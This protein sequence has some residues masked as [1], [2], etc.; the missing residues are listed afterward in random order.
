LNRQPSKLGAVEPK[1]LDDQQLEAWL[2]F[3]RVLVA[4]PAELDSEMQRRAGITQFEYG[5]LARLSEAPGRTMRIS[6]LAED[7]CGSLSRLSH[8]INRLE[9]RGWIR[10]ELD[11]EDGRYTNAILTGEGYAKVVAT[12]PG[13]VEVVRRLVVDAVTPAQLRQLGDISARIMGRITT[14]ARC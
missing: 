10:R 7:A 11:P 3:A 5:V 4:L 13:Q 8:L 6:T 2:R 14:G 1:W 12:A 9:R